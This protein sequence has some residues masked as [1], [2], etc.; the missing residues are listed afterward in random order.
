M[1]TQEWLIS[2]IQN[3]GVVLKK[4][5]LFLTLFFFNFLSS[6]SEEN[7]TDFSKYH[8]TYA[9]R[10]V[11]SCGNSAEDRFYTSFDIQALLLISNEISNHK[12]PLTTDWN[13]FEPSSIGIS[14]KKGLE[15]KDWPADE[16]RI[17]FLCL[18][19]DESKR[20]N[21]F[22]VDDKDVELSLGK[23]KRQRPWT[24]LSKETSKRFDHLS[25]AKLRQYIKMVLRADE[26]EKARGGINQNPSLWY[27]PFSWRVP[28]EIK[29]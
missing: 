21:L 28:V 15:D 17:V 10:S 24:S 25:E 11:M 4:K 7:H 14:D 16:R 19:W 8:V 2:S 12:V 22:S 13:V 6:Y 20:L 23:I 26:F 18:A 27:I 29:K 5:F 1:S 3:D 9:N